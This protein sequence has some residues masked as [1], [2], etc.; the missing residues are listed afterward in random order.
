MVRY[1]AS[2][3][4]YD[5]TH[6]LFSYFSSLPELPCFTDNHP[7]LKKKKS[8]VPSSRVAEETGYKSLDIFAGKSS[9]YLL[10]LYDTIA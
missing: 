7:L 10:D 4:V 8:F 9:Y 6:T 3:T 5:Q 1:Y 2:S